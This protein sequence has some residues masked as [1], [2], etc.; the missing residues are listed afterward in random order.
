MNW[1]MPLSILNGRH[2]MENYWLWPLKVFFVFSMRSPLL[3]TT[4]FS[5]V[6]E[7]K[8]ADLSISPVHRAAV[9]L[10]DPTKVCKSFL[11]CSALLFPQ[12]LQIL[13]SNLLH[14]VSPALYTNS[15]VW[16]WI[17]CSTALLQ[18]WVPICICSPNSPVD[19]HVFVCLQ[20]REFHYGFLGC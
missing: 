7:V 11:S 5:Q 10:V 1:L 15:P 12:T 14:L 8:A 9:G 18:V 19:N 16:I 2:R 13:I 4:W 20:C 3:M 6:W 17:I